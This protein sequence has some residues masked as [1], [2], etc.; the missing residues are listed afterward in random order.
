MN[1]GSSPTDAA[2]TISRAKPALYSNRG[3]Y[4][5]GQVIDRELYL[6]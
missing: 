2:P 1:S 5:A 3:R 4:L 6:L